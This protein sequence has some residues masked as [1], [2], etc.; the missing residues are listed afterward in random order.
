VVESFGQR[1]LGRILGLVTFIDA[2]GAGVGP[3][4]AGQLATTTGSYLA[5]FG[6]VTAVAVVAVLNVMLIRP[7][8]RG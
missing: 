6:F 3:A 8:A 2:L 4:I 5:P 7:L 1:E